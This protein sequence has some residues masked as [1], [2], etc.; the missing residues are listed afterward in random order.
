MRTLAAYLFA[1]AI[2]PIAA[3]LYWVFL[4]EP[5]C[6]DCST[7]VWAYALPVL[8]FTYPAALV[9]A[10]PTVRLL[11]SS[12]R[13]PLSGPPVAGAALALL[14]FLLFIVGMHGGPSRLAASAAGVAFLGALSAAAFVVL[15]GSERISACG[16]APLSAR[17]YLPFFALFVAVEGGAY[18]GQFSCGGYAIVRDV[19][20]LFFLVVCL[21][22]SLFGRG[23]LTSVPRRIG[24][25]FGAQILF[26]VVQAMSSPFYPAPPQSLAEYFSLF[27]S[28]L[29]NGPC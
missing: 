24:L 8:L 21:A 16:A 6:P 22:S 4:A 14:V 13:G 7:P 3:L 5:P 29:T 15:L 10:M 23:I 19:Y 1:P 18:F 28:G 20:G 27:V 11:P 2:V 12:L 17:D 25:F 9:I 26:V